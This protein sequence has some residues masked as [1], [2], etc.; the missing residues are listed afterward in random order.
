V[1]TLLGCLLH[2][3]SGVVLPDDLVDESLGDIDVRRGVYLQAAEQTV[4][5][6]FVD[7]H[8]GVDFNFTTEVG[9]LTLFGG[10]VGFLDGFVD[11]YV[12]VWI[13]DIVGFYFVTHTSVANTKVEGL[14]TDILSPPNRSARTDVTAG[15]R[16]VSVARTGASGG[17]VGFF[18]APLQ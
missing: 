15:L 2:D 9:F 7:L 6:L 13:R 12:P 4:R 10:H 18:T 14:S 17:A 16:A 3:V 1:A 5:C 8:S 11:V